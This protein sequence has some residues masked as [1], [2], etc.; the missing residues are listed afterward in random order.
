[1]SREFLHRKREGEF[2][3]YNTHPCKF[4]QLFLLVDIFVNL[5]KNSWTVKW[6]GTWLPKTATKHII[7]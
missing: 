7:Q 1:M 4:K 2:P 6:N 5:A 3:T